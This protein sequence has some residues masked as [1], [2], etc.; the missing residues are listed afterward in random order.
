MVSADKAPARAVSIFH[1]L[2]PVSLTQPQMGQHQPYHWLR[3]EISVSY[4]RMLFSLFLIISFGS[5]D[6]S[7]VSGERK[8]RRVRCVDCFI[9]W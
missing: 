3:G 1:I 6:Q 2:G 5:V 7:A 9:F 8:T 4:L